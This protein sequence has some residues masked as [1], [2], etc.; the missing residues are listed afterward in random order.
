MA[1]EET[2]NFIRFHLKELQSQQETK[3]LVGELSSKITDHQSRVRGLLC[4]E[5]LRHPEVVPLVLGGMAADQPLESNFFPGL[6]EG[7]L[8]RLGIDA[9][10]E[11]N[12]PTSSQ[13]GAGRLWSSAISQAISQIEQREVK[14]PTAVGLPGCLDLC[15]EALPCLQG[16]TVCHFSD[17][18]FIPNMSHVVYKVVKPPV[19]RKV[20]PSNSS[21]EVPSASNQPEHSGP[22]L[23]VS[24]LK[25]SAPSTP[26]PSPP[27]QE[28]VSK[29]SSTNS[30]KADESTPEE[31][32]PP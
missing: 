26:R 27:A 21:R 12:P 3:N 32:R 16:K 24:K 8:G 5:P 22:E 6:L 4:S 31:E 20:L 1:Q 2:E 11:G 9:P 23:E 29:A 14:A 25:E 13:E 7:L 19:V 10:G 30:D 28:R 17:P 18:L 15:Y